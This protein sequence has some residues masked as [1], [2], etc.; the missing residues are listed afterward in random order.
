MNVARVGVLAAIMLSSQLTLAEFKQI[1]DEELSA[2][3]GQ[4]GI[5]IDIEFGT[6]VGEFMYQ[7]GGSLVMQGFRIGGKDHT[8]GV[9]TSFQAGMNDGTHQSIYDPDDPSSLDPFGGG[10]GGINRNASYGGNVLMN[11]IRIELDVAGDGSTV[12]H[13]NYTG[14]FTPPL[15]I[16]DNHFFWAWG[17]AINPIGGGSVGC[18]DLIYQCQFLAN[19]GDLFIHAKP[20][21]PSATPTGRPHTIADFGIELDKFALKDSTY[22]AGDDIVDH[23]GT[24]STAQSTT[25]YSNLKMEGY[26]GG[27]DLLIENKGNGFGEYD[28]LGVFTETGSGDAASKILINTFWEITE[29]E[30][31]YDII[32]VRYEQIAI[33][34][35]RGNHTMFDMFTQE[36]YA[37]PIA[38]QG[39]SQGYAQSNVHL[40]AVKDT[41]LH[42]NAAS[43]A[44]SNNPA[45]YQDGVAFDS[46]FR[47]DMDIGHMS[48]GD[49]GI[50]IGEQYYTD[51]DYTTYAVFSAH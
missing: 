15:A 2:V 42:V 3:T 34:N 51:M 25:I 21:D 11:N 6:E 29:M 41:V 5:T 31:D 24:S 48:F 4:R 23:A 35:F 46:R 10:P 17:D 32:G 33:H 26:F 8:A 13:Y 38:A 40:Y 14:P 45:H 47:G 44:G 49:T 7:D 19:D 9:G 28:D 22:I 18:G 36:T 27:F 16:M 12:D 20:S 37:V 43:A 1:E 30:Y 50:S 39:T